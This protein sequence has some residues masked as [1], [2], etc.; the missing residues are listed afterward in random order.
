[1]SAAGSGPRAAAP[2]QDAAPSAAARGMAA[3]RRG[4]GPPW[5]GAGMPAEKS[6]E[7]RP[8][9]PAAARPAAPAPLAG[10][11]AVLALGVVQ[12]RR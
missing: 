2:R 10:V 6:I 1:M 12:R 4:G 5:A 8:V 11:I 7:L 3:Q 9:G